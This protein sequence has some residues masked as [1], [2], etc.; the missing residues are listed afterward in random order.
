MDDANQVVKRKDGQNNEEL[1]KDLLK[2]SNSVVKNI[3]MEIDTCEKHEDLKLPILKVWLLSNG[4]LV[5]EHFEKDVSS[6]LLR[7]ERSAHSKSSKR[8]VHVSEV[9]RRLLN[10][11]V[12]LNWDEYTV[13]V[14]ND[15]MARMKK[16]G[17]SENYR[18]H[19]LE[20]SLAVNE[21]KLRQ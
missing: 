11:S 17:Y 19:I 9:V 20:N 12:K 14:L 13:P 21:K 8:S 2:I 3:E 5:Y 4:D 6:K 16:A 18:K 1:Y 15:Y 10:T 7:P